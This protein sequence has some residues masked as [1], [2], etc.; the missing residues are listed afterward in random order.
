M[1]KK[2]TPKIIIKYNRFLDPI[3]IFFCK[4]NPELKKRGWNDWVPPEKEKILERIKNYKTEWVKY[5]SEILRGM[6]S[7]L[8]INFKRNIID[9]H[10]VSGN[11]RDFS[12]PLIIKSGYPPQEF[13]DILSH[14][15][16]HIL[17][18]DNIEKIPVRILS[19][20]FP[21]ESILVRN[22]VITH[23]VLKYIYLEILKDESRLNKNI[24]RSSDANMQDYTRAWEIVEKRGY[25]ELIDEFKN[26][27]HPK[28]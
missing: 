14:E 22:H 20:M 11:P 23:A 9:V 17:F 5:E 24:K 28:N 18:Q 12:D 26:K 3:F 2:D 8:D 27:Y 7:V 6:C 19:E 16:I 15:L 10:I 21:Q 25:R 13:V 1:N 4:N